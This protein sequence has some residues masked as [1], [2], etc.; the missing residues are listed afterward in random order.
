VSARA[1]QLLAVLALA[2]TILVWVLVDR[3]P[4]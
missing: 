2:A 4:L 1:E 3:A